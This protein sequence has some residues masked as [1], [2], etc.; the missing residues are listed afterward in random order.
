MTRH[1]RL[2]RELNDKLIDHMQT[3]PTMA[4]TLDSLVKG[5]PLP[6]HEVKPVVGTIPVITETKDGDP[7]SHTPSSPSM[8][9]HNLLI[10]EASLRAQYLELRARRRHHTFFLAVL[11]AWIAGFT[12]ARFLA[13]REDGIGH[14]GSV[15]WGVEVAENVCLLGGVITAILVWVTGIWDRG[16][17]WPRRWFGIS[18]RGLRGFN[19][20]IVLVRRHWWAEL[21][22]TVAFF[23]SYGLFSHTASSSY[24]YVDALILREVDKDLN[25]KGGESHPVLPNLSDDVEKL[26]REEDL[27]PGGDYVKLLLLPKHFT[28]TFRENWELYRS[29]YW[30]KENERRALILTKLQAQEREYAQQRWGFLWWLPWHQA[31]I[32]RHFS[33]EGAQLRHPSVEKEHQ[34]KHHRSGS[35]QTQRR[36]STSSSRSQTPTI[37]TEEGPQVSRKA[38]TASNASDKRRKKVAAGSRPKQ[39]PESRSVTPDIPSP[40]HRES[41][42]R[43]KEGGKAVRKVGSRASIESGRERVK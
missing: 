6:G 27:A 24:R 26:G 29:A 35:A 43:A 15:Y 9:Y 23:L 42:L 14:G 4:D 37:E 22:S 5:A 20:K 41:S 12:Y 8:I 39:R 21:G 3:G 32:G 19:C 40:L 28:A 33:H 1:Q 25:L 18:N 10:L 30:E 16:I 13:P 36:G 17:R 11:A 2:G 31:E 38:S 7:L 34:P